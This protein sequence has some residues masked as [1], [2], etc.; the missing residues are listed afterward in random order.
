MMA[1]PAAKSYAVKDA[2]EQIGAIFGKNLNRA[3]KANYDSL[4]ENPALKAKADK[5]DNIVEP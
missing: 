5:Y 4:A 3:D 1:A 2:A